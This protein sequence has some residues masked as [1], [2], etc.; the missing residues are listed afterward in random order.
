MNPQKL[1][2]CD[3]LKLPCCW[4]RYFLHEQA[5]VGWKLTRLAKSAGQLFTFP[6]TCTISATLLLQLPLLC[7]NCFT[8][9]WSMAAKNVLCKIRQ[10]SNKR[11]QSSS[12][13]SEIQ[14]QRD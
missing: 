7:K 13:V 14:N 2:K 1:L 6:A 8:D 9:A 4:Q 10:T 3:V 5:V 12:T 11:D